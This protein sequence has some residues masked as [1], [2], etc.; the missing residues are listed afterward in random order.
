MDF[1]NS[2]TAERKVNFQQNP[3][4][5]SHHTFSML[6]QYSNGNPPNDSVECRSIKNC[7]LRPIYRFMPK[8]IQSYHGTQIGHRTQAFEW[9]PFRVVTFNLD[10]KVRLLF[11]VK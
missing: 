7:D 6:P 1:P 11:N 4:N 10:F 2:F 5:A 3:Y 9:Y 8:I